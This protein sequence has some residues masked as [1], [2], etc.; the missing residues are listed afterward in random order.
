MATV[1]S[2]VN[3]DDDTDC[4]EEDKAERTAVIQSSSVAA[5]KTLSTPPGR[6]CAL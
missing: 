6:D 5:T 4:T 3:D 2:K 1:E